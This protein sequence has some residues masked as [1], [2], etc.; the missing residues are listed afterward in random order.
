MPVL[1][2]S[3][4][5]KIW[6][7]LKAHTQQAGSALKRRFLKINAFSKFIWKQGRNY[8]SGKFYLKFQVIGYSHFQALYVEKW[9]DKIVT[10]HLRNRRRISPLKNA[11]LFLVLIVDVLL[12]TELTESDL[13]VWKSKFLSL[14]IIPLQHYEEWNARQTERARE[15]LSNMIITRFFVTWIRSYFWCAE[16]LLLKRN[17][18]R[19]HLQHPVAKRGGKGSLQAEEIEIHV[20][21]C[22]CIWLRKKDLPEDCYHFAE[23]H[24]HVVLLAELVILFGVFRK[25]GNSTKLRN[26]SW[27]RNKDKKYI[28]GE[29]TKDFLFVQIQV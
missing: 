13:N 1:F 21:N 6:A 2:L 12:C 23:E 9:W 3:L 11:A 29:N 17:H 10:A 15:S 16:H 4:Y 14:K 19:N 24:E 8:F 18:P 22:R 27:K 26:Y 20:L 28:S 7:R 5:R 25:K